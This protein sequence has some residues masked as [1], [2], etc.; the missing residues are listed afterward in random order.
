MSASG[1]AEKISTGYA[2]FIDG[3]V[4]DASDGALIFTEAWMNV[5]PGKIWKWRPNR[6]VE[7]ILGPCKGLG[8]T[9]DNTGRLVVAGWASRT[10]WRREH[11]GSITVLASHYGPSRINTPNDVVVH[12]SGAIYW[13]DPATA[14][15]GNGR[16]SDCTDDLQRYLNFQGV[17]RVWPHGAHV[18]PIA[19]DFALPNGITFSPDEHLLYVNDTIRQHIRVFDLLGDGSLA[20]GRLFYEAEP[21]LPGTFDGMKVDVEGNVYCTA[22]GGIHVINPDGEL[23][24]RIRFPTPVGNIAWGGPEWRWM[25][26]TLR[27]SLYRIELNI[28]GMPVGRR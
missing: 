16:G 13:T 6:G 7:P 26:C 28:P 1:T 27:D 8:A 3:P 10:I 22:A 11:D 14:L 21:D 20:N 23:I 2:N 12:S 19:D 9:L 15:N 5:T 4:W 17:F 25:F 24:V 18:E